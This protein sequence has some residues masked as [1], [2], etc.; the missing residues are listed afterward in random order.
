MNN[1][2]N[3]NLTPAGFNT[4]KMVADAVANLIYNAQDNL[5]T[6]ISL[7]IETYKLDNEVAKKI[8]KNLEIY[9]RML[10]DLWNYTN[11]ELKHIND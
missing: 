11:K 4:E 8:Q 9:Q 2:N 3:N 1:N 5:S 7:L 6:A 10:Q